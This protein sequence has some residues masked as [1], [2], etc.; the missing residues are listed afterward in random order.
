MQLKTLSLNLFMDF[1]KHFLLARGEL[2]QK[3][4]A[5]KVSP[6][7]SVRTVQ[8]WESGRRVPPLWVQWL[9]LNELKRGRK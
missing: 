3:E 6:F 9:V 5:A 4:A 1:A 8:E 2:S 7:L